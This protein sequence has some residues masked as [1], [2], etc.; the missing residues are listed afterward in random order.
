M[1]APFTWSQE[2]FDNEIKKGGKVVINTLNFQPRV[3]R[4]Y[5]GTKYKGFPSYINGVEIKGTNEDAYEELE[6]IFG[7]KKIFDYSKPVN[8]VKKLIEAATY[9]KKNALV[10]DFFA[11]S[12]GQAVL[13]LNNEDGGMRKFILCTNNQNNICEEITYRRIKTVIAGKRMDGSVYS[14]GIPANL[15]YYRTDF[16]A[17]DNEDLVDSLLEHVAEMIQL[18][19]GIKLDNKSHI[20]I[21][22]DEE[23]DELEQN[24]SQYTDIKA[25]YVAQ[26]VLLTASQEAL[27]GTADIHIIPDYYFNFE[28]RE[29][30]ELW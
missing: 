27:F 17:K 6:R 7:K 13:E 2:M 18:E 16:V 28:L 3:F 8:L 5:D 24:W 20:M 22:N 4:V 14:E 9:S 23:A 29:A 11:G 30:G 21:M 15:K 19:H 1:R 10:L 12:G 25:I 26:D